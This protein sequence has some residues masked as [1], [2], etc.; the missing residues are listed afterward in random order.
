[1]KNSFFPVLIVLGLSSACYAQDNPTYRETVDYIL[2]NI[3]GD[4]S[5]SGAKWRHSL[6]EEGRC[7]FSMVIDKYFTDGGRDYSRTTY[8]FSLSN[9]DPKGTKT[10][11]HVLYGEK[12]RIVTPEKEKTVK[13]T[14]IP[15]E[16]CNRYCNGHDSK[17]WNVP[18]E[19]DNPQKVSRAFSH[20]IKICGG[21]EELF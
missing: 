14:K 1:M 13:I 10:E 15:L 6:A 20:L 3:D 5:V 21:K 18:I 9:F 7:K 12:V 2:R 11:S 16:G 19:T 8:N 17:H 4:D